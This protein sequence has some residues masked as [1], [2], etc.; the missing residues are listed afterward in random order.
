MKGA[1]LS[2]VAVLLAVLGGLYQV[3]LGPLLKIFGV[4][5]SREV[6]QLGSRDCETI[7]ELTGCE[8]NASSTRRGTQANTT[9]IGLQ[10]L[11]C[12]SLRGWCIWRVPHWNAACNG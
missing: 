6:Q 11:Y 9:A 3:Y 4:F 7:P 8:S 5:P 2:I 12:T 10:K 1:I